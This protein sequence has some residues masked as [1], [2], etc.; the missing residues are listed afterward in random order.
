M[1][2][3]EAFCRVNRARGFELASPE[4]LMHAC[5]NLESQHL[6]IR[7]KELG[8]NVMVLQHVTFDEEHCVAAVLSLVSRHSTSLST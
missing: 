8:V 1:S 7:L 6:P 5:N 4:D 2:L 3:V